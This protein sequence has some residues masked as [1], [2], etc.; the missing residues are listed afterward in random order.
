MVRYITLAVA[1]G[2]MLGGLLAVLGVSLMPSDPI[3]PVCGVLLIGVAITCAAMTM[4]D[5]AKN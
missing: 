3:R 4:L 5:D 1:M 2:I